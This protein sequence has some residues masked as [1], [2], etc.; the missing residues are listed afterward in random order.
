[1]EV[2][3]INRT[4]LDRWIHKKHG[5]NME[6][7]EEIERWQTAR[8]NDV[9][10]SAKE[11]S[12]F[13]R[14]YLK[15]VRPIRSIKDLTR[16][17]FTDAQ[18]LRR[19]GMRML[20]V[21]SSDI[22]RIVTLQT[23]GTADRPKRLYFTL[24]DQELTIDFFCHGMQTLT[25]PGDTVCV[26]L[27]GESDGSV[28]DLLCKAIKRIP[29]RPA[30]YGMIRSLRDASAFLAVQ[31][32]DVLVGV[33]VQILA[34]AEFCKEHQI[35]INVKRVLLSTDYA[36]ESLIQRMEDLFSCE[37]FDHL[38]MTEMGLGGAV[39]CEAH[40]GMHI[41]ENDLLI[42]VIHPVTKQVLQ[43]RTEG[44]LVLTTLT[45]EGM[46]LIRYRTEDLGMITHEKCVCG[47][48]L[49]RIVKMGARLGSSIELSG[50]QV[51]MKQLD[52]M[53]FAQKGVIDYH[54]ITGTDGK[55]VIKPVWLTEW[56]EPYR[57]KRSVES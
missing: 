1:M 19:E 55:R 44:E 17:P 31:K 14:E 34:L 50:A 40:Q 52:E 42:E 48:N 2:H 49:A 45:R 46:P 25:R 7:R 35:K 28:G 41:R 53:M 37:V 4:P 39:E 8:L 3:N 47:S 5:I 33:P 43:D 6:C 16:I 51:T 12:L 15:D 22:E 18:I 9:L 32:A 36:A 27:P 20:C 56:L 38:G 10:T 29:A 23:S 24:D 21:P 30:L 57:G 26:Y 13:Y 54:V 11:S